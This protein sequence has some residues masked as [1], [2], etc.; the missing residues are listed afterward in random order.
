MAIYFYDMTHHVDALKPPSKSDECLYHASVTNEFRNPL[1]TMLMYLETLYSSNLGENVSRLVKI[2]MM[3][4]NMLLFSTNDI[5]DFKLIEDN[6]FFMKK[7][8]F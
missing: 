1:S 5:L 7:Q 3:H 4:T 6:K 2:L 8:A